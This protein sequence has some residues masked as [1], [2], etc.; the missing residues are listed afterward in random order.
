MS[1]W[2]RCGGGSS[3][4]VINSE[5]IQERDSQPPPFKADELTAVEFLNVVLASA[6]GTRGKDPAVAQLFSF[7]GLPAAYTALSSLHHSQ[8]VPAPAP[9]SNAMK[10]FADIVTPGSEEEGVLLGRELLAC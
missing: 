8:R 9:G 10:R 5:T 6:V 2:K 1:L 7:V 4:T 3:G